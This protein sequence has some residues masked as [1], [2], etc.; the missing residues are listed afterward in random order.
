MKFVPILF[1][2]AW[3]GFVRSFAFELQILPPRE[4]YGRRSGRFDPQYSRLP[5]LP[6]CGHVLVAWGSITQCHACLHLI[7]ARP[8][9]HL[10]T[11]TPG[12]ARLVHIKYNLCHSKS[13]RDGSCSHGPFASRVWLP[14]SASAR[15]ANVSSGDFGGLGRSVGFRFRSRARSLSFARDFPRVAVA[16]VRNSISAEN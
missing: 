15:T 6:V 5:P 1:P 10:H 9:H 11:S 4:L 3:V 2:R 12:T 7:R 13:L 8:P 16:A 14:W